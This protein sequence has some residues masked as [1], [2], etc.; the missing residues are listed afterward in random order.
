[1][2]ENEDVQRLAV[3]GLRAFI[4]WAGKSQSGS[5]NGKR[6]WTRDEIH[7]RRAG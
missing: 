7:E 6:T 4:E 5:P 2:S 1:M 3:Q